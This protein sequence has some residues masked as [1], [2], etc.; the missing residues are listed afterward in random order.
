MGKKKPWHR[1]HTLVYPKHAFSPEDLLGFLELSPFT[2]GWKELELTDDDLEAL[3]VMIMLRPKGH[4]V[5]P[6]T[7]KMRKLRFAPARW[8]TGKSGAARVGYAYLEERGI[9]LLLIAYSKDEKDDLSPAEKKAIRL[10][11]A[12]VE[13]EFESG[14]IK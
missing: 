1:K 6:G 11:I 5:V 13:K 7:G 8:K 4:P 3:Q 9:I 14:V 12:R 2:E 10:L